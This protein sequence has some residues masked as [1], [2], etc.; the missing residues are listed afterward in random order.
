MNG[1]DSIMGMLRDKAEMW[2]EKYAELMRA[3]TRSGFRTYVKGVMDGMENTALPAYMA[4]GRD[5]L[6]LLVHKV[7]YESAPEPNAEILAMW[8]TDNGNVHASMCLTD[9]NRNICHGDIGEGHMTHWIDMSELTE[10]LLNT[11]R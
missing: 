6:K 9:G 7:G 4:G 8:V 1:F 11:R 5:A 10:Y 3:G 2:S